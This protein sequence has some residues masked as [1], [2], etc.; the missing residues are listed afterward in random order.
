MACE[1]CCSDHHLAAILTDKAQSGETDEIKAWCSAENC[2]VAGVIS[3]SVL[4]SCSWLLLPEPCPITVIGRPAS[5]QVL[6]PWLW[7]GRAGHQRQPTEQPTAR[8]RRRSARRTRTSSARVARC[9][10]QHHARPPG[11]AT[12]QPPPAARPKR[13]RPSCQPMM[14]QL[15]RRRLWTPGG[16]SSPSSTATGC[17]P[18]CGR[19]A[20]ADVPTRNRLHPPVPVDGRRTQGRHRQ[21]RD[22]RRRDHRAR[23]DGKPSFNALQNPA[24]IASDI[25]IAA[26]DRRTPAVFFCL[27]LLH[28]AGR[29]LRGLPYVERESLLQAL[30]SH[31]AGAADP[32][33][34]GRERA[35][36][37]GARDWLRRR[38]RETQDVD[39]PPGAA[40]SPTGSRSSGRVGGV[41]DRWLQQGRQGEPRA[42]R[43]ASGRLLGRRR[44]AALRGKRRRRLRRERDRRPAGA[45]RAAVVPAARLRRQGAGPGRDDVAAARARRRGDVRRMD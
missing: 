22:L 2:C 10:I 31:R 41:R 18:S 7:H 16:C 11:G 43:L 30:M 44:A 5:K 29:N 39:R 33:E 28:H 42:L 20:E 6:S 45:L 1:S 24:G 36:P 12:R 25:E 32:R 38:R 13:S 14:A 19:R 3:R 40:I 17:S 21:G 27:D 23:A 8:A 37:R 15:A 34:R 35:L 9:C 26:A 4:L